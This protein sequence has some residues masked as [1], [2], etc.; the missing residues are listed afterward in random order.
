MRSKNVYRDLVNDILSEVHFN[1]LDE[2]DS[3]A[4]LQSDFDTIFTGV[5]KKD[6]IDFYT[7]RIIDRYREVAGQIKSPIDER[8]LIAENNREFR[9]YKIL[10][11]EH[12]IGRTIEEDEI[13]RKTNISAEFDSYSLED[14][15][16]CTGQ[17]KL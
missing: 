9:L 5:I 4:Y 16:E 1:G 2:K 10:S 14:Y 3:I 8:Y 6:D 11:K 17:V 15:T 7:A 12:L 13:I